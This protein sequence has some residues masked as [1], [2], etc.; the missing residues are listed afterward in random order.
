MPFDLH[1]NCFGLS[2]HFGF[3]LNLAAVQ[4]LDEIQEFRALAC[5]N[6]AV[7]HGAAQLRKPRVARY[8]MPVK[9]AGDTNA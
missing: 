5:S 1:S 4:C 3:Y 2:N 8:G 7:A 9:T 6:K